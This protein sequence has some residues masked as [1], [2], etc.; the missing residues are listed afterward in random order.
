[1]KRVV[2][3]PLL[4]LLFSLTLNA[5]VTIEECV[6]KALV[7]Y[8]IVKKYDLMAATKDID[9]NEVNK[10]WLPRI[11]AYGQIA[12]QNV[13]PSFPA[14]LAGVLDRMGQDM[15][16][17]GKIQYKVGVDVSQTVWDGGA[18]SARRKLIRAQEEVSQAGLDVE[19]YA[20]RER[21][22][23]L[24]FAI[25][26][27]GEHIKQNRITY[28]LLLSNK[29]KLQSMLANG[30]AMQ[31]DVDMVEAQ[32]L[33]VGQTIA[34]AQTSLD[35]YRK[36]LE[37][38]IG[39]NLEGKDFAVPVA[40]IPVLAESN[41]PELR[42]FDSEESVNRA[43]ERLANVTL[44]PKVGLFAQAYYG[45][46]GI[47]YFQSMMNRDMSFNILAGVKIS[48]NI[49][50]FY[51]KKNRLQ[52]TDVSIGNI[53]VDRELF[54]FNTRMQSTSQMEAINGLREVIKDDARIVSLRANVRKAAESQLDN[55]VID[56]TTLLSK[57]SDE[58]MAA[59]NAHLHEI[60]LLQEIYKLKYI[61]NR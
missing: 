28:N 5:E 2:I 26:L 55:G 60:Q 9:L 43:S 15:K 56:A 14:T 37:L 40:E 42:L 50:S 11:G 12:G 59:L 3:I 32:A 29:D 24:Y 34:Q 10:S 1:M 27:I 17:I 61:L 25:L 31:C 16:G 51:T 33:A 57:I 6:E 38:F 46:P 35:G 52:K 49:D 8:P 21:V 41:R 44:M 7:N 4:G 22:E 58:N 54:M 23:N 39:E 19:L 47:N 48:W 13:V 20:V 45:Y 53:A 18:S 30:V 36:M